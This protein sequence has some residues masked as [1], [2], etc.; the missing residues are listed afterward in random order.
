MDG[1]IFF[2]RVV[3]GFQMDFFSLVNGPEIFFCVHYRDSEA[4]FLC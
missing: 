2:F 4:L 3:N 1:K